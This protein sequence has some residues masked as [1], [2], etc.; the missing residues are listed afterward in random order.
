MTDLRLTTILAFICF[1]PHPNDNQ[2]KHK[3]RTWEQWQRTIRRASDLVHIHINHRL[4]RRCHQQRSCW[5][6]WVTWLISIR[7]K[8]CINCKKMKCSGTSMTE[9]ILEY[10]SRWK[11]TKFACEYQVF[12]YC[13]Y[14][15]TLYISNK[16]FITIVHIVLKCFSIISF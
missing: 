3:H 9:T 2:I 12:A 7:S 8:I 5:G 1:R 13:I 6:C 4:S 14:Y 11:I 16:G 10:C 15:Y